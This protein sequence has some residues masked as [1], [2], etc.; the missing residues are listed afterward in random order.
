MKEYSYLLAAMMV[1]LTG[2]CTYKE[3]PESEGFRNIATTIYPVSSVDT[4][5]LHG[6]YP[7]RRFP[8]DY[9]GIFA[10]KECDLENPGARAFLE[11]V[12]YSSD[13]DYKTSEINR[14]IASGS[15]KPQPL[16]IKWEGKA[17]RVELSTSPSFDRDVLRPQISSESTATVYNL[18]PGIIY[19]YRVLA[20]NGDVLKRACVNPTGPLRM[21]DGVSSNVRDLGGW[22]VDGG[23]IAYGKLYRGARLDDIQS[24]ASAKDMLLNT[25]GVSVDLDLRGQPPGWLGGSG[26]KNPWTASDPIEYCNIQLWHYFVPSAKQYEGPEV[27]DSVTSDQYQYAIRSILNWLSEG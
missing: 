19:F 11:T 15:D 6:Q 25:L 21:I 20:E 16:I 2:A 27:A 3:A 5:S 12:D 8:L 9:D 1:V 10:I 13:R 18:V 14:F 17:A 4:K 24:D 26:E 22:K 23:H 7:W